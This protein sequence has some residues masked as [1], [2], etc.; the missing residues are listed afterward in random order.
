MNERGTKSFQGEIV[1]ATIPAGATG[2]SNPIWLNG[3][4][5]VN[6]LMPATWA[7]ADLTLQASFDGVNFFN[8][9]KEDGTELVIKV[10]QQRL[11][12]LSGFVTWPYI[13]LR[14]GTS[15]TPVNQ[16]AERALLLD[17]RN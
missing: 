9:Y 12:R 15:A 11:I 5:V 7:T 16:T 17:V 3:F 2:L 4:W 14:S 13:K 1:T 8:V 10:A 6:I